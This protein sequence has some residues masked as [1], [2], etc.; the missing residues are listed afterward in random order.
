MYSN[1]LSS[2]LQ[3]FHKIRCRA[4]L[5]GWDR[6]KATFWVGGTQQRGP[7]LPKSGKG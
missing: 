3:N 1:T 2:L 6:G 7:L 4:G 5:L